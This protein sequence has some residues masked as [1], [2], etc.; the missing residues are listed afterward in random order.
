MRAGLDVEWVERA[1]IAGFD[2]GPAIKFRNQAQFHPL[3]YLRGL[4]AAIERYGGR[5][6]TGTRVVDV[7]ESENGIAKTQDGLTIRARRF[8]VA[9]NTPINDR[10]VI[11]T[12]QAPYTTYVIGLRRAERLSPARALLGHGGARR[13]GR[14]A[15]RD[16]SLSLCARVAT[17]TDGDEVLVVG[18]EDHKTGQAEISSSATTNL[19]EW[20]RVRWPQAGEV[21]FRWSG[22]VM[23]P[24]DC[25]AFIGRNPA[26]KDN[27]L[28]RHR[29]LGQRHDARHDCRHPDSRPDHGPGKS[30]GR[31]STIRR[32]SASRRLA[33]S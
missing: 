21:V 5:I 31:S 2:T 19:E 7:Q 10:Y 30:L 26:D 33:I 23:E 17:A 18:G 4:A 14:Q 6:Y 28:H 15:D 27:V 20:T 9:T 16:D 22:Q 3:H 25:M 1:P 29:R 24:E 8:V 12:K 13:A 11:H 32:A